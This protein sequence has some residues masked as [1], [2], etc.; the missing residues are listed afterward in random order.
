MCW[1]QKRRIITT[2]VNNRDV[3][4]FNHKSNVHTP[5]CPLQLRARVMLRVPHRVI[6]GGRAV[7]GRCHLPLLL[8]NQTRRQ[9]NVS[10]FKMKKIIDTTERNTDFE[11]TSRTRTRSAV[12]E[13]SPETGR[14]WG[15]RCEC[16]GPIPLEEEQL[17]DPRTHRSRTA[18]HSC[19]LP[20]R[21]RHEKSKREKCWK[22]SS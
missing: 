18:G 2:N 20:C 19:P 16:W 22:C 7:R 12:A 1:Q 3:A 4:Q 14:S 17:P 8:Q 6:A 21:R 9:I 5:P 15:V 13:V 11:K 10:Q